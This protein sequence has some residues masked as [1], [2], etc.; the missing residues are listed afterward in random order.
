MNS[1]TL[2]M[3]PATNQPPAPSDTA[4]LTE[5]ATKC[6]IGATVPAAFWAARS[7]FGDRAGWIAGALAAINPF[8]TYYAQET[9][10]YA[11]VMLLGILACGAF[12]RAFVFAGTAAEQPARVRRRWAVAI[13]APPS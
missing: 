7:L 8:L 1:P 3:S 10:M 4:A 9:R 12:A 11:L 6:G 13:A 5:P 2:S